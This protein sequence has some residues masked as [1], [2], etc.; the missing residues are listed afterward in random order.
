MNEPAVP[1]QPIEN[2]YWVVPGRLLAGEYPRN[3]D[4]ESSLQ[5]LQALTDAGISLFV[6]LT[7][8]G[9]PALNKALLPYAHWLDSTTQTHQRFSIRDVSVPDS[10]ALTTDILDAIDNHISEGK[11]VYVHCWGGVGR[12]GLI[13]GCWLARH[14]YAGPAALERLHDLWRQCPK[15]RYQKS[16]STAEQERY[17]LR[18]KEDN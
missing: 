18:W 9:E 3:L 16:P 1:P 12:T 5:K 11:T 14:G 7:E 10:P 13:V 8:A 17:I 6:D 15:S 2:C 4:E